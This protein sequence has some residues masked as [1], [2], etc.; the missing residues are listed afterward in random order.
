MT[1]RERTWLRRINQ[2][3]PTSPSTQTAGHAAANNGCPVC[4]IHGA[5]HKYTWQEESST[6]PAL[7]AHEANNANIQATQPLHQYIRN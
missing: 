4:M 1:P 3:S 2:E 5:I 6:Q 7:R